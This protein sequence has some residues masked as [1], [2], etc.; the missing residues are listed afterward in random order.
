MR[1]PRSM[2]LMLLVLMTVVIVFSPRFLNGEGTGRV[3]GDAIS[4]EQKQAS[5]GAHYTIFKLMDSRMHFVVE[6]PSKDDKKIHLCIPAAFT[7]LTDYGVDG[8][9]LSNGKRCNDKVNYTLGGAFKIENGNYSMFSTG[10]G[11]MLTDS[12]LDVIAARKGSLFQQIYM[13]VNG[14]AEGFKDTK[15]FQ[16]RGIVQMKD[17]SWTVIESLEALTLAD[18][19]R[20]LVELGALNAMYTDMGAWDEGWYREPSKDKVKVI[21]QLRSET[22]KQTNWV[23]FKAE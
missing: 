19:S 14:K 16:R 11:K 22:S 7:D 10:K 4:I 23:I 9:C 8:A 12:L 6:R 21:G 1:R 5:S 2:F 20:D 13:V 15:R 17:K 18:F 3:K